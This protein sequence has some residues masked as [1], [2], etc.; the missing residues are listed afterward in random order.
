MS[1]TLP[2]PLALAG[3]ADL[4]AVSASDLVVTMEDMRAA[5]LLVRPSAMREVA[6]DVPK[7]LWSEI[8]GQG[9]V[10][11]KLQEAV[12]WP[13]KHPDAFARMGMVW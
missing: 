7:V 1:L 11:Q 5:Q 10:K 12:S 13:L 6:V 3:S 4:V 9:D 8:G 2:P